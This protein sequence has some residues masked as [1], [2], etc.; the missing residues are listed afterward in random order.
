[1]VPLVAL[2]QI[3]VLK[4]Q[5]QSKSTSEKEE[6]RIYNALS[7]LYWE[8]QLDSCIVY[9]EKAYRLAQKLG[10]SEDIAKASIR[11][12]VLLINEEKYLDAKKIIKNTIELSTS[13]KSPLLLAMAYN[14][15]GNTYKKDPDS[16]LIYYQKSIEQ[17]GSYEGSNKMVL[18]NKIQIS[19]ILLHQKKYNE[20]S[21]LFD[22]IIP[23]LVKGKNND[24]LMEI[25]LYMSLAFRDIEMKEKSLFYAEKSLSFSENSDNKRLKTFILSALSSGVLSY[26]DSF[27]NALP[28]L[29]QSIH[30]ALEINDKKLIRTSRKRLAIL[31]YNNDNY[32]KA[33]NIVNIL[34]TKN[35]D[36][37]IFD[38]KGL[39][40]SEE[41][42]YKEANKFF[43]LAYQMYRQDKAY[44]QQKK[45]II[46]KI[47][48]KLDFWGDKE[49]SQDFDRLDSLTT[50]I[51]N[52][53]N[54][55]QFFALDTKYRTAEKEAI[56]HKKNLELEKSKIRTMYSSGVALLILGTSI[57][58]F[59]FIRNRQQK[60]ELIYHNIL[61]KLNHNLNSLEIAN[62]NS[63]LNP[64][65]IKN[66]ITSISPDLITKAPEAYKKMI[67]LLNVTRASL[68][69][70]LTESLTPQLKQADDFLK[71]QQNISPY[72][73]EYHI[74]NKPP[75]SNYELPRLLVKNMVE[76]AL[77][78][79]ISHLKENGKIE[80]IASKDKSFFKIEIRD[81]GTGITIRNN[82][83]THIGLSTYKNLFKITNQFNQNPAS[84]D[85][86]READWTVVKILVPFDY[87]YQ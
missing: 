72:S 28:Y 13:L 63:R 60:K 46:S 62:L 56:I 82:E 73:W 6:I 19:R 80:V 31:Y 40:L 50:I 45:V 41:G 27:E 68:S 65:E 61:L 43:D 58:V 74:I 24:G 37:D 76:N 71:L 48:N 36:P 85:I 32:L 66:L 38:L 78:H 7:E 4:N 29:N 15:L 30:L 57:F 52:T 3:S 16:A 20:L 86:F 23:Q 77:K 79:G 53:E 47:Y 18:Q 17:A 83:S 12:S 51:H 64:H 34:L 54:Q 67:K 33:N 70:K 10:S 84:L 11:K 1:M 59:L 26:F 5:L 44:V 35:T 55:E 75:E 14:T 81:N 49:L 87:K 8:N 42:K 21:Q 25:Y 9:T 2:G 69:N 39:L 22:S